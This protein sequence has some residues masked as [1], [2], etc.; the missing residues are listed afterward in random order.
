VTP[1]LAYRD[2]PL[3]E[4]L[5]EYFAK[6]DSK[7]WEEALLGPAREFL[8]RP[9]KSFRSTLV[10]NTCRLAG[11]DLAVGKQLGVLVELVHA[12]SLIIDDIQDD[13]HWRRG[14]PSLH[15]LVGPGL[16]IN[17]A[18]WLYYLAPTV[19]RKLDL[20]DRSRLVILELLNHTML[21]CHQ[22]QALDLTNKVFAVHRENIPELVETTT[23]LKT[24]C[25]MELAARMGAIGAGAAPKE[26]ETLA[27]FGRS[28]GSC[29]QILDDCGAI[30]H[31]KRLAKGH[32]D[33]RLARLTWPWAELARRSDD[34]VFEALQREAE[35]VYE[36]KDAHALCHELASHTAN[37]TIERASDGLERGL[38]ELESSFPG[39][40]PLDDLTSEIRR[41]QRS[42][43]QTT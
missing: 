42:Y 19:L 7:M 43:V 30:S 24:G 18:N 36:G 4:F 33:L 17:T 14:A 41:L 22:G 27:S 9:G 26:T 6:E 8:A 21:Q 28:L 11:G 25:L 15:R 37:H 31:S 38:Q 16:A 5:D 12:G 40:A 13:S 10:A 23:S 29:L 20:D 32:E 1:L 3:L 39:G 35:L 2:N 34:G